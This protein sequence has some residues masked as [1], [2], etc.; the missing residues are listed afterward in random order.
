MSMHHGCMCFKIGMCSFEYYDALTLRY[1]F[2]LLKVIF[3]IGN[4]SDLEGQVSSTFKIVVLHVKFI[5]LFM[6]NFLE[7]CHVR[8]SK[9]ICR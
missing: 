3:L 8:R 7:R 9:A 5:W 1:F 6:M 2:M 4:K